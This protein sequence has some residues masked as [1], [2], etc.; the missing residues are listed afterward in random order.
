MSLRGPMAA[1]IGEASPRGA[2]PATEPGPSL[3]HEKHAPARSQ[4][5][6]SPGFGGWLDDLKGSLAITTMSPG[7]LLLMA[8]DGKGGLLVGARQFE[9]PRGISIDGERIW[10]TVDTRL[11]HLANHGAHTV[12]G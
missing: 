2:S 11:F 9:S 3:S 6:V 10:I 7:L 4:M 8:G 12:N 5:F 1:N